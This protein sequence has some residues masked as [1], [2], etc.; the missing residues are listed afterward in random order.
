PVVYLEEY[1]MALAKY[2]CSGVDLWLNTPLKPL[3]AS[4]TSG[5]KTALNGIPSLSILDGWWI[6]G[7]VESVTGWSIDDGWREQSNREEEIASLYNKLEKVILPMYYK[8][9][10]DYI[11]VMRYA[12]ALNG[13]HFNAQRMVMQY[14]QNAYRHPI[15]A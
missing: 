3:E 8:A 7:H 1:D 11:A 5:M 9:P 13:P 15:N 4:G 6:E 2:V 14:L 12:I 10:T